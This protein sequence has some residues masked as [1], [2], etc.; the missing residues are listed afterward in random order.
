MRQHWPQHGLDK[1]I[2]S[3]F[4]PEWTRGI[5]TP[6]LDLVNGAPFTCFPEYFQKNE[7]ELDGPLGPSIMTSYTR[8]QRRL[9]EGDQRGS[10]FAADAVG[11]VVP[12]GLCTDDHFCAASAYAKEGRFPMNEG[13]TVESDLRCAADWTVARMANLAAARATCYKAVNALSERLQPLSAHFRKFQ[14]GSVAQ[15]AGNMHIAFLAVAVIL[16]QWPDT[17]LPSRYITGFKSLGMLEH[18][19][20]LRPVPRMEP[21]P[22]TEI[23]SKAPEITETQQ[24]Q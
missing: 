5:A 14:R 16:T 7:Q 11:Q 22:L 21:V 15:V 9:A 6:N 1:A 2:R 10:F 12:L 18:T 24:I 3:L 20:V 8:G 23:W 17:T 13:L 19:G 4:P